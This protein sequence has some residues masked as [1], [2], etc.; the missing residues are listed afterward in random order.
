MTKIRIVP[1][2]EAET[3]PL[4]PRPALTRFPRT[5]SRTLRVVVLAFLVA[6][7]AAGLLAGCAP[8]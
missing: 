4:D 5:K 7:I 3:T 1:T 8:P 2:I 6:A